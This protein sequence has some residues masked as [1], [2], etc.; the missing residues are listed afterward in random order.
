MF[1][2]FLLETLDFSV[3]KN[4]FHNRYLGW[5]LLLQ[6]VALAQFLSTQQF[7]FQLVQAVV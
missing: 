5:V 6:S 1:D 3:Y 7:N 2:S 4:L